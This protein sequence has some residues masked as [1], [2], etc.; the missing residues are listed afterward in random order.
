LIVLRD[1]VEIKAAPEQI[2]NFFVHFRENFHAWHPDHLECRYLNFEGTPEEGSVIHI[3]EYLHGKLHKLNLHITRLKPYSRIEYKTFLGS[4]GVFIID[5]RGSDCLFTAEM[6]MGT[7]VRLL[8]GLVDIIMK[9]FMS[10]Q[11]QGIKQ[12]MAE[13]GQNL[14]RILEKSNKKGESG[15]GNGV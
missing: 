15:V 13:E 2:F 7:N 9:I 6:Y 3:E 5:P 11:L 12:H 4:K 10:R 1:T 14:K 8:A